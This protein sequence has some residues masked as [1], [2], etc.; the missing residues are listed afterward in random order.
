MAA[1]EIEVF[2]LETRSSSEKA[3][4]AFP[5]FLSSSLKRRSA[6]EIHEKH[7]TEEE[8][9]QVRL[10]KSI[11]VNNF[12]ASQAFEALPEHLKPSR[13]QAIRMRWIMSWK[14]K[15]DGGRKAKA[16]AVLLG[17]QD[18]CCEQTPQ[19]ALARPANCNFNWQPV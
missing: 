9:E 4:S 5:P 14:Y 15:E 1:V 13:D 8:E 6:L 11:E 2:M 18:P 17:Y 16:K 3:M 7:L 19:Q 10:A 12:I